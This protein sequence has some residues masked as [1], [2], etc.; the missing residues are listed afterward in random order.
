MS[1]YD[2]N[3]HFLGLPWWLSSKEST[4]NVGVAGDSGWIPGLGRSPGGR[5]GNPL[6]YSCLE[7]PMDRG[8]WRA[9]V[10]RVE[11]N[12]TRLRWLSRHT[13]IKSCTIWKR[14]VSHVIRDSLLYHWMFHF[15]LLASPY[16]RDGPYNLEA[17]TLFVITEAYIP[18]RCLIGHPSYLSSYELITV[19]RD[20]QRAG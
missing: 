9:M 18:R 8:A 13:Y 15:C 16:S 7:N 14:M 17:E 12:W 20:S 19:N 2:V 10:C 6:Q 11:K 4:C 5:Y 3:L 1:Y